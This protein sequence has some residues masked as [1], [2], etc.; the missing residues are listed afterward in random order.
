MAPPRRRHPRQRLPRPRCRSSLRPSRPCVNS[1]AYSTR[2]LRRRGL[3]RR[4]PRHLTQPLTALLLHPMR[5]SNQRRRPPPTLQLKGLRLTDR[6]RPNIPS[7]ACLSFPT[8]HLLR[9]V[10]LKT[11]SLSA[12]SFRA[13]SSKQWTMHV[14]TPHKSDSVPSGSRRSTPDL[15]ISASCRKAACHARTR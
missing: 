13:R 3:Q 8:H 12:G 14:R 10:V 1:G 7:R 5:H 11:F 9:V 2:S 6:A 15:L 4:L